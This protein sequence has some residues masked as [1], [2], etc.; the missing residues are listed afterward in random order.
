MKHRAA[1][2]L[3]L[4]SFLPPCAFD[5]QG[6]S[7]TRNASGISEELVNE[8]ARLRKQLGDIPKTKLSDESRTS[9]T[10]MFD[11]AEK[12]FRTG[13][14]FLGLFR[15][16]QAAISLSESAF[17]IAKEDITTIEALEAE[18]KE[19]GP[20]LQRR[21][22]R[23]TEGHPAFMPLVVRAMADSLVQQAWPLYH[24]S[25][26]YG[27]RTQV[28]AGLYYLGQSIAHMDLA[29]FYQRLP[30]VGKP[31]SRG[32]RSLH[33]ELDKLEGRVLDAYKPPASQ[34]QHRLFI[35]ANSGLKL[36]Q[37]LN[38][39]NAYA[40][41][42]LQYLFADYAL[43]QVQLAEGNAENL[44]E[45]LAAFA[46]RCQ[47]P[48]RDRSIGLFLVQLAESELAGIEMEQERP[49]RLKRVTSIV[50]RVLPEYFQILEEKS[51]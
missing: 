42:L 15:Y 2:L 36:A 10:Q 40:G 26:N 6:Q 11:E 22:Q 44:R 34:E 9:L 16:E 25:L 29:L 41:A 38:G 18:W 5:L 51:P 27:R 37:E 3:L 33:A 49:T 21:E 24:S 45:R 32:P 48:D 17:V 1:A 50:E 23:Y 20:E 12:S 7:V 39:K 30:F 4:F 43:D 28:Q 31:G 13:D 8:V 14:M 46:A 35:R 47:K 19:W